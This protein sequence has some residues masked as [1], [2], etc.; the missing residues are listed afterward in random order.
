MQMADFLATLTPD[1]R[2]EALLSLNEDVL[3][4][5]PPA[6]V[7]EAQTLRE[8]ASSRIYTSNRFRPPTN[9]IRRSNLRAV[10]KIQETPEFAEPV[11]T[12]DEL[13]VLLRLLYV[14]SSN[15]PITKLFHYLSLFC[16]TRSSMLSAFLKII[17][18]SRYGSTTTT[19]SLLSSQFSPLEIPTHPFISNC[20]GCGFQLITAHPP[21]STLKT[22]LTLLVH[23]TKVNARTSEALVGANDSLHLP[24]GGCIP[25]FLRFS[26][27][28]PNFYF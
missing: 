12:D 10:T 6:I 2:E 21:L 15:I 26:Y 4:T 27:C 9:S 19:A 11:I 5:L 1:L 13:I 8:R 25:A 14:P 16:S 28:F 7:A 22:I 24:E 18:A 20:E 3:E 17:T 23:L